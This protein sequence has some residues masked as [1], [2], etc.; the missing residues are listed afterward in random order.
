MHGIIGAASVAALLFSPDDGALRACISAAVVSDA[1]IM[2][3]V[4]AAISSS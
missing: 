4:R 2:L 3:L 1:V